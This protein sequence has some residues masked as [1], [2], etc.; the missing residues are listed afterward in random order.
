MR[1]PNSFPAVNDAII[2]IIQSYLTPQ[3][4][5][6][7]EPFCGG[8]NIIS[9]IQHHSRI[10]SDIMPETIALLKYARDGGD[11][12]FDL[13]SSAYKKAKINILELDDLSKGIYG[14]ICTRSNR[15]WGGYATR[16]E[17]VQNAAN[18]LDQAASLKSLKLK[19]CDYLSILP[20][21]VKDSLILVN[22]PLRLGD[23]YTDYFK[24]YSWAYPDNYLHCANM[25]KY[26]DLIE[27]CIDI[28][29]TNTVLMLE[30]FPY[31]DTKW[32]KLWIEANTASGKKGTQYSLYK[33]R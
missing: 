24:A 33:L 14:R 6:Y 2:P 15:Y 8:A 22:P 9:R 20:G 21:T 1:Y 16:S 25:L 10:G 7:I 23:A 12:D 13:S 29:K 27:W 31:S 5:H 18:L 11:F 4:E 28:G 3:T 26:N 17:I 19:C 30:T 32:E